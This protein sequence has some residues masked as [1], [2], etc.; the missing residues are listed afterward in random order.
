MDAIILEERSTRLSFFLFFVLC[1]SYHFS[2]LRC[3]GLRVNFAK[4]ILSLSQRVSFLGTV[5]NSDDSDCFSG[6]SHDNSAPP[7]RPP[8]AFQRILG[9]M[10][11]ASTV[12]QLGLL[13][14]RPI[15]FWLKQRVPS[16]AWH[17]GHRVTMTRPCALALA[18]W[19]DLL[20]LKQG[21][22]LD[23]AYR[24]KVVTTD[25]SNKGWRALCKGK[26][27]FCLWSEKESGMHINCL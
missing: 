23:T 3:L 5:I 21:V 8:K 18:R 14:M 17:H 27:T 11:A 24:R 1:L 22:I 6:A 9:L 10:A 19:K 7:G 12:L 4:S 16:A 15:Q 2:H 13:H 25:A 20:W 26:P